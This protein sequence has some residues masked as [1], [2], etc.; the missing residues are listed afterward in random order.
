MLETT[1]RHFAIDEVYADKMYCTR[2]NY[3]FAR[4][5]GIEAFLDFR[6]NVTGKSKGSPEWRTKFKLHRDQE[7]V[8]DSHYHR[9]SNIEA[10]I[11]SIKA[12]LSQKIRS[13]DPVAQVNEIL[14][15]VLIHNIDVL[16]YMHEQYG[17]DIDFRPLSEREVA[18]IT[19]TAMQTTSLKPQPN[20]SDG[21]LLTTHV[22]QPRKNRR[23]RQRQHHRRCANCLSM[24]TDKTKKGTP[25]WHH[26]KGGPE[27][28]C[29]QCYMRKFMRQWKGIRK[30]KWRRR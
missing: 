6:S 9:R 30:S 13:R 26:W 8:F 14:L 17:I 16:H 20:E 1:N 18:Q 22:E 5:L 10:V 3:N 19:T 24:F 11:S 29:H 25:F 2:D 23:R 7:E 21:E 15:K 12:V 4:R 28:Y 27:W